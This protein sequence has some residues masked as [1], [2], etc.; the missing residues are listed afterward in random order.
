MATVMMKA[1]PYHDNEEL[2]VMCYRCSS[3]N[4]LVISTVSASGNFCL[5]CKQSFV[6]SFVTFGKLS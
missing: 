4:P 2:L 5:N 1:K 3:Y 6:F